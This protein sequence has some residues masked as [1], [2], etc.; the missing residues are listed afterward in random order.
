MIWTYETDFSVLSCIWRSRCSTTPINNP[1][2]CSALIVL[3]FAQSDRLKSHK[4]AICFWFKRVIK[5]NFESVPNFNAME[6][7]NR[8]EYWISC[9]V[10]VL[11]Q[12][13]RTGWISLAIFQSQDI[14]D[15]KQA[16]NWRFFLPVNKVPWARRANEH[17]VAH[18][19]AKNLFWSE[20][21]QWSLS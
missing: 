19:Q 10:L 4:Y 1:F 12:G 9:R 18:L 20:L 6:L 15:E 8:F 17:G 21:V 11:F 13:I 14:F 16:D 5:H 7:T 3:T 2:L